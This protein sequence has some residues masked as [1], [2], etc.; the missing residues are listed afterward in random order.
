M[1]AHSFLFLPFTISG[2]GV[3]RMFNPNVTSDSVLEMALAHF[4]TM[5]HS[6]IVRRMSGIWEETDSGYVVQICYG[7]TRPP[8]RAWFFVS[9]DG[10]SS[11]RMSGEPA[12][13][14]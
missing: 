13:P 10:K 7:N 9:S 8:R 6:V 14:K 11:V 12:K 2:V 3:R 1:L 5:D 4:K